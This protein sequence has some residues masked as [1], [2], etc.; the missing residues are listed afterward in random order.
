MSTIVVVVHLNVD[1]WEPQLTEASRVTREGRADL[2]LHGD[3]RVRSYWDHVGAGDTA[4]GVARRHGLDPETEDPYAREIDTVCADE[5]DDPRWI[6]TFQV[7]E[8]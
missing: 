8:P 2:W 7:E 6:V 1:R 3:D 5:R 4:A